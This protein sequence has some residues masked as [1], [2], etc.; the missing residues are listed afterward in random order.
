MIRIIRFVGPAAIVLATLIILYFILP[1]PLLLLSNIDVD[2]NR[3]SAIGQSYTAGATLLSALA[4]LGIAWSLRLQIKQTD[5]VQGQA[6][7]QFQNDLLQLAMS[8]PIYASVMPIGRATPSHDEYRKFVFATQWIRY[9][10]YLYL[11]GSASGESLKPELQDFFNL[12]TSRAWWE[13]T[14]RY[15]IEGVTRRERM[16]VDLLDD[17]YSSTAPPPAE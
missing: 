8:D 9:I 11:S 10:Q 12:A 6:T 7:R 15:W 16:F 17:A 3:L 2:W 13:S 5:I 4:L 1:I 14:R